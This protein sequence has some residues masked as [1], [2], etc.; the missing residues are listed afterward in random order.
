MSLVG[1][2]TH[3]F[4][5]Y[6]PS[7]FPLSSPFVHPGCASVTVTQVSV[8]RLPPRQSNR[9]YRAADWGLD[10]PV[11]TCRLRVTAKGDKCVV[12]LQDSSS[13]E[14]FAQCPVDTHPGRAV[15]PVTDSSRYFVLRVDDGSGKHAFLGM[16]FQERGDAFDFNVAL[17]DHFKLVVS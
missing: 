5:C 13:G 7:P 2:R 10:K 6:P 3:R 12:A 8:Y 1:F 9:G 11:W 17:Q 16:G 4:S 14:L 15:E